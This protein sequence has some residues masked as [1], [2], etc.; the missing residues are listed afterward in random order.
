MMH[1]WPTNLLYLVFCKLSL[2]FNKYKI[3]IIWLIYRDKLAEHFFRLFSLS[4]QNFTHNFYN[5]LIKENKIYIKYAKRLT[6]L[7]CNVFL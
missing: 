6:L 3:I 4:H 7:N 5:I 2:V 1:F